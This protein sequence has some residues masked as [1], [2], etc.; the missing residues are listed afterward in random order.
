MSLSD[1]TEK[2]IKEAEEK[3][4]QIGKE[5]AAQI[6]SIEEGTKKISAEKK[7]AHALSIKNILAENKKRV[8]AA[9]DHETKISLERE[10]RAE[11]DNIF[12]TTL[13]K[14][15]SLDDNDYSKILSSLLKNL[16]KNISGI[17]ACPAKRISITKKVLQENGITVDITEDNTISG[18]IIIRENKA[19]YNLTF[20]RKM[21]DMKKSLEIEVSS[22]LFS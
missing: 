8:S 21:E 5:S 17:A 16:P 14:L 7:E 4:E 10:K 20:T 11:L 15:E 1:I 3:A 13:K 2:I 12:S 18:G 22:I 6:V 9:A 19:E